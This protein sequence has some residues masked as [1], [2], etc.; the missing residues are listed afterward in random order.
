MTE[1]CDWNSRFNA[2]IHVEQLEFDYAWLRLAFLW[3]MS[4]RLEVQLQPHAQLIS[5]LCFCFSFRFTSLTLMM[6]TTSLIRTSFCTKLGRYGTLAPVL[7]IRLCLPPAITKV[8]PTV[9]F[10]LWLQSLLPQT[11]CFSIWLYSFFFSL[12]L[13]LSRIFIFR[14]IYLSEY[15]PSLRSS[16]SLVQNQNM[17]FAVSRWWIQGCLTSHV[18]LSR[19]CSDPWFGLRYNQY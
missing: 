15:L 18:S 2:I 13:S 17:S 10:C 12:S 8:S 11:S 4:L 7:R 9:S 5:P 16:C 19:S 1:I 6:R 14:F 3:L